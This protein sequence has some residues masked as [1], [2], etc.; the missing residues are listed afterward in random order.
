MREAITTFQDTLSRGS[1]EE[2]SQAYR[3]CAQI[4]DRTAQRGVIH[5]SQAARRKRRLN[6]LLKAKAVG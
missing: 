5:K 2:A 1:V 4:I 6:A 3:A